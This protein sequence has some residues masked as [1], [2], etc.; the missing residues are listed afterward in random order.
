ML[1]IVNESKVERTFKKWAATMKALEALEAEMA[2]AVQAE[3]AAGNGASGQIGPV[4]WTYTCRGTYDW[5]TLAEHLEPEE[6][7]V[8][9]YQKV[10]IDYT[11]LA[12]ACNPTE[13]EK[14]AVYKPGSPSISFKVA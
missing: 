7:L 6:E 1:A 11:G 9:R 3:V 10:V 13:E 14:A 4:K 2:E 12:K 5:K 8:K